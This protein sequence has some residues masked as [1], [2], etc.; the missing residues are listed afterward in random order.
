[1][2]FIMPW[3][4]PTTGFADV[5]V[6]KVSTGQLLAASNIPMNI[7]SPG[8]FV[9]GSAGAGNKLAAVINQ[10]G[11]INDATHPAKRGEYISVYATGQ[12][13]VAPSSQPADGD[14]PR[15]GLVGSLGSL[16]VYLG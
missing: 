14:I 6:I 2:N 3:N 4:A 1:I 13:P 16:R 7:Q 5:Q 10:D 8:I 12:G 15:G 11:S 9:S